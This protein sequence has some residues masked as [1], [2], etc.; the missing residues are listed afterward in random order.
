MTIKKIYNGNVNDSLLILL[1]YLNLKSN[2][3]NLKS[4][5]SNNLNHENSTQF[6]LVNSP[7]EKS[8]ICVN[9]EL[10]EV[11]ETTLN[12]NEKINSKYIKNII[13]LNENI[14]PKFIRF[15]SFQKIITVLPIDIQMNF[16]SD[17]SIIFF[18]N[19]IIPIKKKIIF[20]LRDLTNSDLNFQLII[21]NITLDLYINLKKNEI[22]KVLFFSIDN[23]GKFK[24]N[25]LIIL[26]TI[27]NQPN[28]NLTNKI[29]LFKQKK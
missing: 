3:S 14:I 28:K 9:N 8:L 20:G 27:F 25:N 12:L 6:Y 29:N 15:N 17:K 24:I 11:I 1:N 26:E 10:I 21:G 16:N 22:K 4:N 7:N 2:S 5:S 13:I 18:R 23:N 19:S